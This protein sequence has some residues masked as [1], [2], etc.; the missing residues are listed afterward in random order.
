MSVS[1]R[2][3]EERERQQKKAALHKKVAKLLQGS[4]FDKAKAEAIIGSTFRM[5][6]D[7]FK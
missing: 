5:H 3:K 4:A 2:V 7:D 1:K 6:R